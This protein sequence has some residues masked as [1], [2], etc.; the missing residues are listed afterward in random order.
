MEKLRHRDTECVMLVSIDA[1]GY[2]IQ[3]KLI[4]DGSV[5][6][7][8]ISPREIFLEA[9]KSKAVSILL[10]HN[11]PSGDP[12]PS[13]ADVELTK[14]VDELGKSLGI[15]LVD[16]VIIGDNRYASFRELGILYQE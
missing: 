13:T 2:L 14:T 9:L 12:T 10:V 3:E 5:R 11:H 15:P 1:K 7:S 16:H 8:L 6:M 4:S